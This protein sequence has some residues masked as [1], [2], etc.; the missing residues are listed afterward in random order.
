MHS[1]HSL[2]SFH[3]ARG[4]TIRST[5]SGGHKLGSI[6]STCLKSWPEVVFTNMHTKAKKDAWSHRDVALWL[7]LRGWIRANVHWAEVILHIV[8]HGREYQLVWFCLRYM[9]KCRW[10][11]QMENSWLSGK[12]VASSAKEE[13]SRKQKRSWGIDSSTTLQQFIQQLQE[14]NTFL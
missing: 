9:I 12:E 13:A 5:R 14:A 2:P 10:N 7:P 8:M 3:T 11:Y 4:T 6:S 1:F